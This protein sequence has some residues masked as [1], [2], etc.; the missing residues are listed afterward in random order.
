MLIDRQEIAKH[1]DISRSLRED[2]INPFIDD[3]QFQ[4]LRPLLGDQFYYDLIKNSSDQKYIDLLD[5]KEY[6]YNG[7]TY[8]SPGLKKVL[9]I[10]AYS[11]YVLF[12]SFTDTSFGFVQKTTT[13]SQAV[14]DSQK[15]NIYT[16]E[17]NTAYN[18]W[19]EVANFLNRNSGDYPYWKSNTSS[20]PR[21]TSGIRIS[22]IS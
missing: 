5:Q 4:D 14:G 19:I 22:K 6:E 9:S 21:R 12:G 3:A 16:Q 11:R 13:D 8:V 1:R 10:Y 20:K 15:R 7:V 2:K 17:R 18:Y